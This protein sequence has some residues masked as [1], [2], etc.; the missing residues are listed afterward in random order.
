MKLRSTGPSNVDIQDRRGQSGGGGSIG[1]IPMGAA[2]GGGG[3]A[4]GVIITALLLV[5]GQCSGA[6]T[7]GGV[8]LPADQLG[9]QGAAAVGS[10]SGV[11]CDSETARLVCDATTDVQDYWTTE[12]PKITDGEPYERTQTVFFSDATETGCGTA[13]AQTGPFYCPADHLVYFDL[14]FLEQL[15]SQFGA[16]G[17]FATAYIVAH[18]YGH[19]IQNLLGVSAKVSQLEQRDPSRANE[20]SIRLELQADCLAGAWGA[21][22]QSSTLA[23]RQLEGG[24]IEEALGAA[25]AVGDDRI[26]QATQGRTDPETWNHGDARDRAHWFRVGFDSGDPNQCNTFTAD[27]DIESIQR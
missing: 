5:T 7:Q 16:E 6:A 19:H 12:Y 21:N 20:M 24:D 17:D 4:I 15:Q 2:L 10:A 25:Q 22:V 9:G 8:G 3:G 27:A 23:D 14:G 18:E 11:T 26:Q 13:S 1:G